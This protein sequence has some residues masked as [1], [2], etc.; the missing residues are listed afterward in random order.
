MNYFICESIKYPSK[1]DICC[2]IV[3][4]CNYQKCKLFEYEIKLN[5]DLNLYLLRDLRN[6]K[7]LNLRGSNSNNILMF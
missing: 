5:S 4:N 1:I 7:I 2:T 6:A 3:K